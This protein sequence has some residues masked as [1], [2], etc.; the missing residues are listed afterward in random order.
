MS[1]KEFILV[2]P[3]IS[4]DLI[5]SSARNF[6]VGLNLI[7]GNQDTGVTCQ[8]MICL[9]VYRLKQ[10]WSSICGREESM[11]MPGTSKGNVESLPGGGVGTGAPWPPEVPHWPSVTCCSGT[12]PNSRVGEGSEV[13]PCTCQELERGAGTGGGDRGEWR[14][15]LEKGKGPKEEHKLGFKWFLC[16]SSQY[17]I[18]PRVSSRCQDFLKTLTGW[19]ESLYDGNWASFLVC[20]P[21]PSGMVLLVAQSWALLPLDQSSSSEYAYWSP[22]SSVDHKMI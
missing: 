11:S 16:V 12:K 6:F 17:L 5:S 10:P 4:R 8:I 3:L 1:T 7:W 21:S 2:H 9:L 15:N 20:P 14:Q 13:S 19:K 18:L 22:R